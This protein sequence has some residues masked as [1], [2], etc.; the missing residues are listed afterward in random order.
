MAAVA[1][2]VWVLACG[3]AADDREEKRERGTA[4][5]TRVNIYSQLG[6]E[7]L[8]REFFS[9]RRNGV[10][11]DVGAA[12]A[13]RN[14]TTYYLERHRGWTGIGVDA[15]DVYRKSWERAR[16]N[17]RFFQYAVTDRSGDTITFLRAPNPTMSSLSRDMVEQWNFGG[18]EPEEIEVPTITL[19]DLLDQNG[20][21]KIDFLSIDIEGAEPLALKGFDIERFSPELVC[22]EAHASAENEWQILDYFEKHGYQRIEAYLSRDRANWYFR[23]K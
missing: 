20:I 12:W 7:V 23:R 17:S 15:L 9:D 14:S 21:S 6:E 8:I 10:Y 16:P 1:V 13:A 5:H 22:I 19:T 11:L 4:T 18:R 2:F 3:G